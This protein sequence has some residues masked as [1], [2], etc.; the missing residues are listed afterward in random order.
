MCLVV[1]HAQFA[2][3]WGYFLHKCCPALKMSYTSTNS[4]SA[5]LVTVVLS[6]RGCVQRML[7]A[8]TIQRRCLFEEIQ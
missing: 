4:P 1:G 6:I 2:F 5:S 3:W 8:A 7:A